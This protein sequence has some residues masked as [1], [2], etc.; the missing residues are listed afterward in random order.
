MLWQGAAFVAARLLLLVST[1]VLARFL[2][3]SEYGLISFGLVIV[4]ALNVVSDI[5]VSQALVYLPDRRRLVDSALVIG[6]VGSLLLGALWVAAVPVLLDALAEL[7]RGLGRGL[8]AVVLALMGFGAWSL[9]WAEI[10]GAVAY[11]VICWLMVSHRPGPFRE[12]WNRQ[13][14]RTLLRFGIPTALNGGLAT[15]VQNVDYLVIITT[16]GTASLGYYF[17]GFRIPELVII[18]VF[19]E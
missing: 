2:G 4:T 15:A 1:V 3:P 19:T 16:L 11:A 14:M 17:V 8:V 18:S 13:E 9:V 7:G 12:W 5:G 6:V 10:T